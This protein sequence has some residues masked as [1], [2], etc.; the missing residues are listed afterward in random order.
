M[1]RKLSFLLSAVNARLYTRNKVFLVFL[2]RCR[3]SYTLTHGQK[4]TF[5]MKQIL[6]VFLNHWRKNRFI[7]KQSVYSI[8]NSLPK[9]RFHYE[10]KLYSYFLFTEDDVASY[11]T[12][13]CLNYY[14]VYITSISFCPIIFHF[15]QAICDAYSK[16]D[17]AAENLEDIEDQ[18]KC[19]DMNDH[20][21]V[22]ITN[23]GF[24]LQ[25]RWR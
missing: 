19:V 20:V 18:R 5:I 4:Y 2:I 15:L 12:L 3:L 23:S 17:I 6:L 22:R 7:R 14:R 24:A 21:M 13:V 11:S 25:N 16:S 10:V 9:T 1:Q 8:S